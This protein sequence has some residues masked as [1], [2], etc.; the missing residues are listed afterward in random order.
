MLE[1]YDSSND[2]DIVPIEPLTDVV[3][4]Y[5]GPGRPLS[6]RIPYLDS[7]GKGKRCRIKR[8]Q[9]LETLPRFVGKWFCRSDSDNER[10][11][12]TASMLMLLKPW[13]NLSELKSVTETFEDAYR[14]FLL[15]ADQKA[16]RVITNVQY[17][18]ECSDGAKAAREKLQKETQADHTEAGDNKSDLDM[19]IDNAEEI[20]AARAAVIG[21]FEEI[22]DEDIERAQLVRTHA[23]ERLY[24]ESAVA[25]GYDVGFFE[26][27]DGSIEYAN[28]ARTMQT[29]EGENIKTWEALLMA[30]TREQI[31]E[32]GTTNVTD[33]PNKGPSVLHQEPAGITVPD[34]QP[35][36]Y[37][38]AGPS[39]QGSVERVELAK[40]NEEHLRAHDIIEERLKQHMTSE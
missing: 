39:V 38:M 28:S 31:H 4:I 17:F 33:E 21:A 2:T 15:E 9:E 37:Q 11:L 26:E 24:G 27:A 18:Y 16:R 30:T 19:C 23:R 13:R 35:Q 14:Q 6:K 8:S 5:R 36:G 3:P 22:T 7:A 12:F 1:T 40:L 29:E 32:L 34:I 20:E 25:L 10:D